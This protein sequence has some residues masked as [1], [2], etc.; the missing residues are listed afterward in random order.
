MAKLISRKALNSIVSHLEGVRVEVHHEAKEV[1]RVAEGRLAGHRKTGE[2]EVTVTQ[3]E[4]DSFVNLEGEHPESVEFGHWVR[5]KY[6]NPEKP[7][8][9]PGLY[10]ITGAADLDTTPK[11]GPRRR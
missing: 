8:F 6:E 3:G 10:I 5:G 1:G 4:V 11:Q 2:H 9:V 7:K